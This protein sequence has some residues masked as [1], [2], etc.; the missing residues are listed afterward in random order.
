MMK[1]EVYQF[2]RNGYWGMR[3]I[4]RL[5]YKTYNTLRKSEIVGRGV[6][7]RLVRATGVAQYG[8]LLSTWDATFAKSANLN[9]VRSNRLIGVYNEVVPFACKSK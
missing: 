9:P 4:H 2:A 6:G 8:Q 5:D 1:V 7:G 3:A